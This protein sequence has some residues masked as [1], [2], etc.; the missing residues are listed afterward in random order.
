MAFPGLETLLTIGGSLLLD[1]LTGGGKTKEYSQ[2]P[3]DIV[4]LRK[5]IADWLMSGAAPPS[6][7]VGNQF[8]GVAMP[9]FLGDAQT[10]LGIPQGYNGGAPRL[11]PLGDFM[12]QGSVGRGIELGGVLKKRGTLELPQL[13][14][15]VGG[16]DNGMMSVMGGAIGRGQGSM[17]LLGDLLSLNIA[18]SPRTT[19]RNL[20]EGIEPPPPID[21]GTGEPPPTTGGGGASSSRPLPGR[22]IWMQPV[23]GPGRVQIGLTPNIPAPERV[24]A[25]RIGNLPTVT[26]ERIT[27]LPKAQWERIGGLPQLQAERIGNLPLD[28]TKLPQVAAGGISVRPTQSV[29]ELSR[30]FFTRMQGSLAPAFRQRRQEALK[31]AGEASGN[32]TGSG[33]ANVLAQASGRQLA[34]E[35]ADLA[36]YAAEGVQSELGRQLQMSQMGLEA[37]RATQA[38][39]LQA[40]GMNQEAA[41]RAALANQDTGLRAALANQQAGLAAQQ[42]NLDAA[43]RAALANQ[44]TGFAASQTD[45]DTALRAALANQQAGLQAGGMNLDAML[46]A[47][48]ANQDAGLRAAL[49]NQQAGMQTN[50]FNRQLTQDAFNRQAEMDAQRNALLFGTSAELSNANANRFL[51]LLLGMGTAG[52]GS[53]AIVQQASILPSVLNAMAT[54]YASRGR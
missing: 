28:P 48:L 45:I 27:D 3:S 9:G 4:N 26:P 10:M 24:Q 35:R 15:D 41:L 19:S 37:D 12:N 39:M 13:G 47:A 23:E 29:D 14:S 49:A 11:Q 1:K 50:M 32:L 51:Q 18:G 25:D 52:V 34:E 33:F 20:S 30:G 46:R 5:G 53:P 38:A 31:A 40:G 16:G 6:P 36:K 2:I 17:P 44:Q 21:G 7:V 43:L 42:G 22:N 8:T 54:Y